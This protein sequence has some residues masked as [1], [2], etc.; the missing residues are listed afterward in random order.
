MCA[1]HGPRGGLKSSK[2]KSFTLKSCCAPSEPRSECKKLEQI[3]TFE[4]KIQINH[5]SVACDGQGLVGPGLASQVA[6]S[7]MT[8]REKAGRRLAD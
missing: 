4:G 2:V 3:V 5:D 1:G 8:E 6:T 7:T